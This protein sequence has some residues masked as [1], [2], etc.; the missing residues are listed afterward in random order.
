MTPSSLSNPLPVTTAQL[1]IAALIEEQLSIPTSELVETASL[2]GR[3]LSVDIVSPINVPPHDNS[4]MDGFAVRYSDLNVTVPTCL[5]VIGQAHAGQA[6][7]LVLDKG[8][9]VRIMTGAKMP[10]G[11]DTVVPQEALG[12]QN[13]QAAKVLIPCSQTAGQNRRFAGEDLTKGKPAL[14][15]GRRLTPSDMGLIASLGIEKATVYQR[16]RVAFFSTGNEV[17]SLGETL[18]DG[19]IYDSNRYTLL[20]MLAQLGVEVID[21][22][23]VR[24]NPEALE[25]MLQRATLSADLIISSGGVSVGEAD[26]TRDVM[27]KLGRVDFC[28][29]AMRPGR[30]MAVGLV[31]KSLYFGL[32]G[33]PVAVMVTFHFFVQDAIRKLA[34]EVYKSPAPIL[35]QSATFWRKRPGR[36]EFQRARLLQDE[37][38]KTVVETTG[39]QGSGVLRSMSEADCLVVLPHD[40]DNVPVGSWVEI[41]KFAAL[42]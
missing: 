28:T 20:G 39:Q 1:E 35:V 34:G 26:F 13:L 37:T 8:Q 27:A 21:L 41:V 38:G 22:G 24:D 16:L 40:S 4:A 2:L 17:A 23:V 3:I 19:Q 30:P 14:L 18:T 7:S 31:G 29:I 9:A 32:P 25:A 15:K 33:N 10:L 11:A 12:S 42:S 5:E 36:T 6:H